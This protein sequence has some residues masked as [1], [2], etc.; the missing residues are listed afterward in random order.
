MKLEN[1]TSKQ[2][3]DVENFVKSRLVVKLSIPVFVSSNLV[4]CKETIKDFTMN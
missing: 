2:T 3:N 4:K 1:N